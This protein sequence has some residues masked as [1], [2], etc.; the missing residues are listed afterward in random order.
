LLPL[1][2][3]SLGAGSDPSALQAASRANNVGVAYMNQQFAEKALH[4]FEEAEHADAS[5]VI[6][7]VNEGVAYLYLRKL[8]EAQET[9]HKATVLDPAS[10]RA[11][12]SLGVAAFDGGDQDAALADF[13]HAAALDPHDAD[14]HYYIGTILSAQKKFDQA[15]AE[16]NQ[17]IATN[18]LHASAQFGLARALQ[19][20]GKAD[21]ARVHIQRFQEITDSKIGTL[22]SANYG[23]QGRYATVQDMLAARRG[24]DSGDL[25]SGCEQPGQGRCAGGDE[26]RLRRRRL[27]FGP[28]RQGRRK[29]PRCRPGQ[30]TRGV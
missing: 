12:Y 13:E 10:V 27:Y 24:H 23:E 25:C 19:R 8:P 22:L 4:K 28:S 15:V 30:R 2:A 21:E 17:V 6:P 5:A 26:A 3:E 16:F 20:E 7:L 1:R 11:W 9:L 29:H 14:T 18:P